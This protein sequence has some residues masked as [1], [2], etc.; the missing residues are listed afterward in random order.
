[1][2]DTNSI[3]NRVR[4]EIG[5]PGE[6]FQTETQG[7]GLTRRF[8]LPVN[9][10]GTTGF[11][12]YKVDSYNTRTNLTNISDYSVD[13][14]NGIITLTG[15]L[16]LDEQLYVEGTHY[17]LF[18][19]DEITIYV[20]DALNKH[21][22]E[23]TISARAYNAGGFIQFVTLPVTLSTLPPVEEPLVALLACI[24]IF[25]T[26]ATDAA[27][28]IDVVTAEGTSIPR[29][30]RYRQIMAH[31]Q[32]LNGR[33]Q[34]L[35]EQLNVGFFRIEM[36]NLRRVSKTTGRYVPIYVDRE[37]DDHSWP[38]RELPPIDVHNRDSSGIANPMYGR[39]Y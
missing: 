26:M 28:D 7:D 12:A 39:T 15:T 29:S 5:D 21:V 11:V 32:M 27:T 36:N 22:G 24:D 31:L 4:R 38:V 17:N 19:N 9:M 2:A 20:G 34:Q 16:G 30:Q 37:F 6:P 18:S 35:C 1:M 25:W 13:Y 3:I 33:Y 14:F 8:E 10:V 23:R